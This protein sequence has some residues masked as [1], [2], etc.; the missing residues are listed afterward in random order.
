[1]GMDGWMDEYREVS[2]N[3]WMMDGRIYGFVGDCMDEE[4]K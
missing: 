1:M 3:L 2:L 4:N